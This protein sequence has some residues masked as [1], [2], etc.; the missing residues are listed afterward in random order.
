MAGTYID[1]QGRA[2][3]EHSPEFARAVGTTRPIDEIRDL[4]EG[5]MGFIFAQPR[6]SGLHVRLHAR[7]A[8]ELSIVGLMYHVCDVAIEP[9][10]I[11]V[12]DDGWHHKIL[13]TQTSA[14]QFLQTVIDAR[15]AYSNG[16]ESRLLSRQIQLAGR[17]QSLAEA[18]RAIL[19]GFKSVQQMAMVADPLFDGR[20][21]IAQQ[22]GEGRHA[23]I[24]SM[25]INYRTF[26][27]DWYDRV[28]GRTMLEYQD[29]VYGR[30]V[31]EAYSRALSHGASQLEQVDAFINWPRNY[32][33][34]SRFQRLVV[35]VTKS[36]GRRLLL[37]A[38]VADP[39]IDLRR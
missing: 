24:H 31:S 12:A 29:E 25:G 17:M 21:T 4:V 23:V 6:R 10:L 1:D 39:G 30:W 5:T 34:R 15:R 35:P 37:A 33:V 9:I 14:V 38:T 20:F 18:A 7:K 11:S 13:Q 28:I 19:E 27:P 22:L 2:W 32:I 26:D 36:D 16:S 3:P 8:T